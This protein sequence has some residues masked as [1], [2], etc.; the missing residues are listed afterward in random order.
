MTKGDLKA[1]TEALSR[2]SPRAR[3]HN[4]LHQMHYRPQ[5]INWH[6]QEFGNEV[7]KPYGL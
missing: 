6:S 5:I 7:V 2:A 3:I 4:D 1:E